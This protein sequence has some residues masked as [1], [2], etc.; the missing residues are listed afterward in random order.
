MHSHLSFYNTILSS[1]SGDDHDYCAVTHTIP[2]SHTTAPEISVKSFSMVMGVRRP[3]FQLLSLVSPSAND[4]ARQLHTPCH[5]PDQLGIYMWVYLPL[6]VLSLL[7][8]LVAN[9]YR[10]RRG[11]KGEGRARA[12]SQ[13]GRAKGRSVTP[14]PGVEV[15]PLAM[16]ER[17]RSGSIW[18]RRENEECR[19]REGLTVDANGHGNGNGNGNSKTNEHKA[20]SSHFLPMPTHATQRQHHRAFSWTFVLQGTRRRISIPR[21]TVP[22]YLWLFA[23]NGG[24]VRERGLVLGCICDVGAVAWPPL[25]VAGVVW[26]MLFH[27]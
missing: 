4:P 23:R 17:G 15:L 5:L 24:A 6:I 3:G 14:E 2:N 10:I 18:E 25:G 12:Y 20:D 9:V 26:C 1:D 22:S 11:S 19:V 7:G 13:V 27:S 16:L 8:I 21:L